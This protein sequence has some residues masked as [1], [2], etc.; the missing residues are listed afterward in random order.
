MRYAKSIL[1]AGALAGCSSGDV[2]APL[3][4]EISFAEALGSEPLDGRV[5]LVLSD[6][7]EREPR[8][9]RFVGRGTQILG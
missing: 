8:L 2:P 7:D 9:A 6:N 3:T 1:L 5:L 4:F